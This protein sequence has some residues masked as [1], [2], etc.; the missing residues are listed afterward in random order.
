M[1]KESTANSKIKWAAVKMGLGISTGIIIGLVV[2]NIAIGLVIGIVL[3]G[4]SIIIQK[5]IKKAK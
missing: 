1:E 4:I 3:G 5:L 2:K